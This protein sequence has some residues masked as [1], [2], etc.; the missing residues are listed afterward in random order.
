MLCTLVIPEGSGI[1]RVNE[2]VS[3][4]LPFPCGVLSEPSRLSLIK[5]GSLEPVPLQVEALDHWADGSVKWALVDFQATVT[6]GETAAYHLEFAHA[7]SSSQAVHV[8][9]RP[10]RDMWTI[11]TECGPF[12]IEY[13]ARSSSL[14]K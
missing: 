14:M 13:P 8:S 9:L 7:T 5:Q 3:F 1:D 11:E 10:S 4:G 2:P 6:A 12:L